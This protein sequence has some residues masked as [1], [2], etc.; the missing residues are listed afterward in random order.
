MSSFLPFL[1]KKL[2]NR[3]LQQ[4]VNKTNAVAVHSSGTRVDT[5]RFLGKNGWPKYRRDLKGINRKI[6]DS[7]LH[8][9]KIPPI[10]TYPK[11]QTEHVFTLGWVSYR[12]TLFLGTVL[13]FL[14]F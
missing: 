11:I 7:H 1:V 12:N 3:N 5:E 9:T 10:T 8:Y 2:R 13:I 14:I 4:D 6:K